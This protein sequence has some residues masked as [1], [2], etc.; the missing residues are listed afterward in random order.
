M[1]YP[2]AITWLNVIMK[3]KFQNFEWKFLLF[4]G[5]S[6]SDLLDN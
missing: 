2:M 6:Y 5:Q 4:V 3:F 1:C